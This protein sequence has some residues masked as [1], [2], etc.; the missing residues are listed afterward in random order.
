MLATKPDEHVLGQT[1]F[2]VRV[3]VHGIGSQAIQAAVNQREKGAT[4]GPA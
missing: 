2:E 1:E 3:L 4:R